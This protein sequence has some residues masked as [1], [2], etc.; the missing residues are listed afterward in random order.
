MTLQRALLM[1]GLL[2]V[3]AIVASGGQTARL[4]LHRLGGQSGIAARPLGCQ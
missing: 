3:M 4:L 1:S 2:R